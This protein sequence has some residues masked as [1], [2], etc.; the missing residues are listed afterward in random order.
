MQFCGAG[1]VVTSHYSYVEVRR[2]GRD[3]S[4]LMV[5]GIVMLFLVAVVGLEVV[6]R[7]GSL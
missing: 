1:T 2:V 4:D 3:Y 6:E 5:V 7:V